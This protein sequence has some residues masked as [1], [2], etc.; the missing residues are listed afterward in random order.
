MSQKIRQEKILT[1]LNCF[2]Y[3]L[4]GIYFGANVSK[5]YAR[6][7][8]HVFMY[9]FLCQDDWKFTKILKLYQVLIAK[10]IIVSI[11]PYYSRSWGR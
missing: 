3:F 4:I 11:L 7:L 6:K 9:N 10:Y 1:V 2:K 8:Y 5:N